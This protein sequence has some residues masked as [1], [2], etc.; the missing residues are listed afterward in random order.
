MI[1]KVKAS[2]FSEFL[3]NRICIR[4]AR[5]LDAYPVDT[6]LIHKCFGGIPLYPLLKLVNSIIHILTRRCSFSNRLISYAD[7][8]CK[9]KSE[10]DTLCGAD[11]IHSDTV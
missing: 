6:F 9:V 10:V 7:T 8:A 11:L 2:G 1:D 4:K 3:K 5:D